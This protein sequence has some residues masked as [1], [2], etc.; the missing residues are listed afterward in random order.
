TTDTHK[1]EYANPRFYL[2]LEKIYLGVAA[3][4]EFSREI[5]PTQIADFRKTCLSYKHVTI[6]VTDAENLHKELKKHA[7]LDFIQLTISPDLPVVG[8]TSI[9]YSKLQ[10]GQ[11]NPCSQI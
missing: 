6:I 2:P 7:F 5:P 3:I 11:K 9:K 4:D 1:I 8:P 10:I